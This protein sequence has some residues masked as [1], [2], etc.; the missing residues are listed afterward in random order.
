MALGAALLGG[1]I[2]ISA[3]FRGQLDTTVLG[4]YLAGRVRPFH[5]VIALLTLAVGALSAAEIVTLGYIERRSQLGALRALGWPRSEIVKLI[6]GQGLSIGT[7][8]GLIGAVAVVVAGLVLK[9]GPSALE[10]G[11]AA[12]LGMALLATAIAVAAPLIHAYRASPADAL[13]GE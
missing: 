3:A 7:A 8:G 1:V 11:V 2:L 6:A 10:L 5:L 4:T 12:A 9:A 13:R